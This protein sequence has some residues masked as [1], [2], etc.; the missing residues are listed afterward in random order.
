[1]KRRAVPIRVNDEELAFWDQQARE[2][3]LSRAEFARLVLGGA[4]VPGPSPAE[5]VAG[6]RVPAGSA[7][8]GRTAVAAAPRVARVERPDRCPQCGGLTYSVGAGKRRC[9]P[10]R[11]EGKV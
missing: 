10:C 6:A 11:W 4:E 3:G 7:A 9:S 2:A 5:Q 1:M 8:H